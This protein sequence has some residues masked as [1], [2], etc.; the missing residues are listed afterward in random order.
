MGKIRDALSFL[1]KPWAAYG[2]ADERGWRIVGGQGGGPDDDIDDKSALA[3]A[4]YYACIR[5]IAED[6]AKL[7][8]L[9]IKNDG[10]KRIK[11]PEDPISVLFSTTPNPNMTAYTFRCTMMHWAAGWG[12]GFAEIVRDG[13]GRVRALNPIH[14]SRVMIDPNNP[15]SYTVFNDNGTKTVLPK[16]RM[17][18]LIGMSGTGK[19]GYSVLQLM[20]NTLAL[21]STVQRFAK[22]FYQNS[23]RPAGVLETTAV[24]KPEARD[25][26]RL[27]WTGMYAGPMNAGKTAVLEAGVQY[28]AISLPMKDMEFIELRRF[29]KEEIASWF[30]MPLYKLQD[31]SRAQGWSTLDAQE[32]DYV[33]SCLM[34]WI[35]RFEQEIRRQ[36][37]DGY[38][39]NIYPH[40]E[41]KGLLRGDVNARKA[42][43]QTMRTIGVM[44][45]NE[46]RALE[47]MEPSDD[48]FMDKIYI[49]G[50]MVPLDK[51]GLVKA[52]AGV[53][54]TEGEPAPSGGAN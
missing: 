1:I 41:F 45:G 17:F 39:A 23:A 7:P 18:K 25:A 15:D 33:S 50:A 29:Q 54:Q 44:T 40:C 21:A 13:G 38:D 32:T 43:Y 9:L 37:M 11:L 35:L 46:I 14:P 6:T 8:F 47:D 42:Y 3:I 27:A 48:P 53:Q 4:T 2:N 51:A 19:D 20:N 30:R 28:K 31:I 12:R 22:N 49:Q 36:L 10:A 5:N 34:P 26:L 52:S 16:D 24:L